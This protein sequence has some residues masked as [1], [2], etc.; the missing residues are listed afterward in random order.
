MITEDKQ[1][2]RGVGSRDKEKNGAVIDGT[3]DALGLNVPD[4]VVERRSQK[5]QDERHAIDSHACNRQG[6]VG[7]REIDDDH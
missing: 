2:D 7:N 4:P 6:P 1:G 3:K 5:G